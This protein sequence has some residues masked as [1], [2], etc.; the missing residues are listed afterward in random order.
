[1]TPTQE[2]LFEIGGPMPPEAHSEPPQE[3]ENKRDRGVEFPLHPDHRRALESVLE[4]Y[5]GHLGRLRLFPS[6][7][8]YRGLTHTVR[9]RRDRLFVRI[10]HRFENEEPRIIEA[11]GH[12]LFR[13]LLRRR[14]LKKEWEIAREAERRLETASDKDRKVSTI[15]RISERHW[16]PPQGKVYDLERMARSLSARFFAS[17][18][19]DIPLAWTARKVKGYWGKYFAEPPIIVLNR[20]LDHPKVPEYVVE[21]VLYH[22]MLHHHLGIEKIGGRRRIHTRAFREAELRYPRMK[23]AEDFLENFPRRIRRW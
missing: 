14:P 11:V 22:E 1:M 12:I 16:A 17:R 10:S 8:R 5:N 2:F 3:E 21:A 9:I 6:Y 13:K 4:N 23:A 7:Y 15:P 19:P 18:F 20:K